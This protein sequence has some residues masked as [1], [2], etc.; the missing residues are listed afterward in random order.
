MPSAQKTFNNNVLDSIA[1]SFSHHG[2]ALNQMF[3]GNSL[4]ASQSGLLL[5][6]NTFWNYNARLHH[7]GHLALSKA[8]TILPQVLQTGESKG[9]HPHTQTRSHETSRHTQLYGTLNLLL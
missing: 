3:S 6:Y 7:C 8:Q 2:G 1:F 4:Q 9:K 5:H